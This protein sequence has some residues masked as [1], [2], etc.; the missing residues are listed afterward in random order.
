[1]KT[2]PFCGNEYEV[3][4]DGNGL[5]HQCI[6][7]NSKVYNLSL[8]KRSN[9]NSAIFTN[10]LL[11]AKQEHTKSDGKCFSCEQSFRE[12]L[13]EAND[14]KTKVYVC[15]TCFLFAIKNLDL[16]V[17]KNSVEMPVVPEIKMSAEA[18]KVI[19]EFDAQLVND[20]KSWGTFDQAVIISK[21]KTIGFFVFVFSLVFAFVRLGFSYGIS[22]PI[23]KI[24][25]G[26]LFIV[27]MIAGLLLIIG[28]KNIKAILEK[29]F[30]K[31]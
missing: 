18:E 11:S 23:G 29:L 6:K 19:N 21:N 17:F 12:V 20:N 1:M 27:C 10:L 13:Y 14:Y 30:V 26:L 24:F 15:P 7:C 31:Q 16:A 25:F 22:T 4:N 5:Y 3:K 9:Y 28:K 2:C 8:L